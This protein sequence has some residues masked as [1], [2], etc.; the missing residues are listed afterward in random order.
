LPEVIA[1][2]L[3]QCF[4]EKQFLAIRRLVDKDPCEKVYS[5]RALL[6][7]V[8]D[9][10]SLFTRENYVAWD[11]L[12]YDVH[13][14]THGRAVEIG[15]YRHWLYDAISGQSP[16]SRSRTDPL[17]AEYLTKTADRLGTH[18]RVKDIVDKFIAHASVSAEK[19]AAC[20]LFK[21][22]EEIASELDKCYRDIVWVGNRLALL[23]DERL[24]L[25]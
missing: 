25:L 24:V 15:K 10:K 1:D 14:E 23:A 13:S 17:N 18:R 19:R 8:K 2:L 9:N 11:G 3:E 22:V 12:P 16:G 21:N 7:D 5:L 6:E 20:R 4:I